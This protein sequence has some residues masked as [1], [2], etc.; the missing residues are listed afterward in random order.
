MEHN[1]L[2][3]YDANGDIVYTEVDRVDLFRQLTPSELLARAN[4]NA[5]VSGVIWYECIA[6][7]RKLE[8]PGKWGL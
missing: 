2:V 6:V 4:S 7:W 8:A 1:M 3:L 5:V